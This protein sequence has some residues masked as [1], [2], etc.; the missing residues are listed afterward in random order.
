M[1]I[2]GFANLQSAEN[3]LVAAALADARPD[4]LLELAPVSGPSPAVSLQRER[5][6]FDDQEICWPF[7]AR[8]DEWPLDN[9]SVPA[10]LLRHVWQ[11]GVAADPLA[12]VLRVLKPGGWLISV[13]ANPWHHRAWRELGKSCLRLPSW[14]HFQLLH[15]RHEL[16]L[17][18]PA[19]NQWRGIV[20]GLT[21]VLVLMA[22]KPSR[23]ARVEPLRFR[24]PQLATGSAPVSLCRAA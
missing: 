5:L 24:R 14:P 21:P 8:L 7:R 20:P 18:I 10:A 11:P 9:D 1:P 12:E 22:R 6:L 4:W 15:A 13:S 17:S 19:A 3:R 23:P 16:E 2:A